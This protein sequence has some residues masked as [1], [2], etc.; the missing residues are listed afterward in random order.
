MVD[1]AFAPGM[2][3]PILRKLPLAAG[4][5]AILLAIVGPPLVTW[6]MRPYEPPLRV[7]MTSLEVEEMVS[8]PWTC[9]PRDYFSWYDFDEGWAFTCLT[10]EYTIGPDWLGGNQLLTVHFQVR[11]R[12]R[13]FIDT[14]V[15]SWDAKPLPRSRPPWLDRALKAIGWQ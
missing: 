11:G 13:N 14:R 10:H 7:G 15:T 12:H 5:V 6:S 2:E 3:S 8:Q 9:M 4:L 1:N